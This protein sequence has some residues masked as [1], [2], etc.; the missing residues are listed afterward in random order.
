MNVLNRKERELTRLNDKAANLMR[1]LGV[2]L[3]LFASAAFIATRVSIENNSVSIDPF[4]NEYTLT[5][6]FFLAGGFLYALLAYH[7]TEIA[8]GPGAETLY[9]GQKHWNSVEAAK[10]DINSFV[11]QW[12]KNNQ[13]GIEQDHTR[14][15]KS[16]FAILFSLTYLVIGSMAAQL[17]ASLDIILRAV[18][19]VLPL[20][21]TYLVYDDIR[22]R[23]EPAD[24]DD[25]KSDT[26]ADSPPVR[27]G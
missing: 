1:L 10:R 19:Y 2:I 25:S 27:D 24:E 3:T 4:I 16:K 22:R 13:Q 14:L 7:R 15:F 17:L 21:V 5:S 23:V 8:K 6:V 26:A 11:P 18:I 9:F 12:V 20:F